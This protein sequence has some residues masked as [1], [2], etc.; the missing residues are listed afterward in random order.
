[1]M[2]GKFSTNRILC[3]TTQLA[4]IVV[5]CSC[6]PS[7]FI[8]VWTSVW[9]FSAVPIG[10]VFS[11]TESTKAFRGAKAPPASVIGLCKKV[12]AA[13]FA[14]NWN[15][16]PTVVKRATLGYMDVSTFCATKFAGGFALAVLE[17]LTAMIAFLCQA[18]M[19][20]GAR[21][22]YP[23]DGGAS[24]RTTVEMAKTFWIV[25]FFSTDQTY[26]N[27]SFASLVCSDARFRAKLSALVARGNDKGFVALLT[28]L[29][30][31]DNI[32]VFHEIKN[33]RWFRLTHLS[34]ARSCQRRRKT[35]YMI[36]RDQSILRALDNDNY[37]MSCVA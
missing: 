1:M 4:R 23:V 2:Y 6:F 25:E 18:W 31:P 36:Y 10:G 5:S 19:F 29:F 28:S 17:L 35:L 3:N 20:L 15:T 14:F 27:Y 24:D 21:F 30:D 12:L 32:R 7:L 37:T 34:R 13:R 11:S 8:P 22:A 9:F 26:L 33:L 16:I